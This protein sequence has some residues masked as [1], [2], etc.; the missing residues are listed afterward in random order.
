MGGI[1]GESLVTCHFITALIII[2]EQGKNQILSQMQTPGAGAPV[3]QDR[4]RD[5]QHRESDRRRAS[6]QQVRTISLSPYAG[7]NDLKYSATRFPQ[8]LRLAR[9]TC[10][11]KSL[12]S[13]PQRTSMFPSPLI[14]RAIWVHRN[15]RTLRA[16][17]TMRTDRMDRM[18]HT[19]QERSSNPMG[20]RRRWFR[21]RR[22]LR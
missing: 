22:R 9:T 12:L 21:V 19:H 10:P 8:L 14:E 11:A 13:P 20:E 2:G 16:D 17:T 6:Q 15:T 5:L 18:I 1:V 4:R 3:P 7:R